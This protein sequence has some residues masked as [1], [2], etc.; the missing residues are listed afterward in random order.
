MPNKSERYRT[1]L[2]EYGIV[3]DELVHNEADAEVQLPPDVDALRK[4]LLDFEHIVPPTSIASLSR[5][6][7]S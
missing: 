4:K 1:K 2:K 3:F 6:P 5:T 7:D